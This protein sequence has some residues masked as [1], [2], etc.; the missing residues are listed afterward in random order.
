MSE[1]TVKT[2]LGD[3]CITETDGCITGLCWRCGANDD[4]P[5]LREA[6]QQLSE[7]FAGRRKAFDLP[8]A[9]KGTPFQQTVWQALTEIP[10]G[11]TR[12]YGE[13]AGAVGRKKAFRAVGMANHCN[14][15]PIIIPCHRVI[16]ADGSLTG[17]AY[18][19]ECKAWLLALEASNK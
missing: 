4:T 16:G 12:T 13:I 6:E 19:T 2:P 1:R 15:I 17:Y 11:E 5:L 8:L 7:Y 9:P 3:L 18:G 14:P 10:Y